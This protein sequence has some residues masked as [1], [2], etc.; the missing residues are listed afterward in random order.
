MSIVM[1]G[2][3]GQLAHDDDGEVESLEVHGIRLTGCKNREGR[4]E[5]SKDI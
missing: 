2:M 1:R 3:D 4:T 5:E